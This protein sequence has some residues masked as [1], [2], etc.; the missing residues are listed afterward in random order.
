MGGVRSFPPLSG[1]IPHNTVALHCINAAPQPAS[2]SLPRNYAV[3]IAGAKHVV[4]RLVTVT[5][6]SNQTAKEP[7]SENFFFLFFFPG[8]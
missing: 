7:C 4:P 5:T 2:S 1:S 8:N 3:F 6:C